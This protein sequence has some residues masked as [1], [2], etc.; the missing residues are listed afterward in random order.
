VAGFVEHGDDDVRFEA[1]TVSEVDKIFS[2][3]QPYQLVKNFR[4]FREHICGHL[5]GLTSF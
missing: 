1:F 5:Q 4:Y 2:G 3:Y